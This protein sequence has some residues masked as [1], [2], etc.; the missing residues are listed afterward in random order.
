MRCVIPA[1]FHHKWLHVISMH[2]LGKRQ[3]PLFNYGF[4][5]FIFLRRGGGDEDDLG[6]AERGG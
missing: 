6:T 3:A 4:I 2:G 1:G 5:F